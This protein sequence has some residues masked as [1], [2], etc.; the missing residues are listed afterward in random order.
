MNANSNAQYS[1]PLLVDVFNHQRFKGSYYLTGFVAKLDE[2]KQPFWVITLSDA[3]GYLQMYCRDHT[4]I[5]DNLQPQSLVD[6]EASIDCRGKEPY[7]RCKLIQASSIDLSRPKRLSQLPVALCNKP[8]ALTALLEIVDS[9]TEPLLIEF[10]MNV[11]TQPQVG[12]QYIQCPASANH[13]HN[14][15]GGLLEHSVEVATQLK[16]ELDTNSQ[17]C[18]LAIVGA[19]L[20]DIGKTQT[21]TSDGKRSAIG[22]LIDHNDLT[23]EI[24]APALKILQAKHAGLANSLRHAWTCASEG[25]RYGFKA[26]TP[27]ARL[28]KEVDRKSAANA[29]KAIN[30]FK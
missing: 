17:E 10:A 1:Q 4:C 12:L 11:L 16:N 14:Y 24:C 8:K 15:A 2:N 18:D 29:I 26:K 22:Y 27:V 3:T 30:A 19:L 7:F 28:L 9:L 20:H 5:A 6:V 23:L 21:F 13:H 25:S